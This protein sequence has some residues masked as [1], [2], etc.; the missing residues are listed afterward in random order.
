MF[1]KLPYAIKHSL[2]HPDDL[3]K[4]RDKSFSG[5]FFHFE[6]NREEANKLFKEGEYFEAL[7]YYEQILSVFKWLEF[8]D[9]EK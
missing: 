2:F 9:K 4:I 5:L 3:K 1:E 6:K 7:E 8:T